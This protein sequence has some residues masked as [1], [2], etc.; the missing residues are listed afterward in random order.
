MPLDETSPQADDSYPQ[1]NGYPT[2][3][4]APL[5]QYKIKR[6]SIV[7]PDPFTLYFGFGGTWNWQRNMIDGI[8]KRAEHCR[9]L[10]Q[11]PPTQEEVDAFVTH[12][13]RSLYHG[14]IGAPVA[15]MAAVIRLY[16]QAK[17][18]DYYQM[19]VPG[20]AEGRIPSP[21]QLATGIRKFASLDPTAFRTTLA[22]TA[23]R[24]FFWT[25]TGA[26]VTSMYSV[27][28]DA[29]NT[30]SDPRLAEFVTAVRE[31]KPEEVR[32]RKLE[33]A[34][35][36]YHQTQARKQQQPQLDVMEPSEEGAFAEGQE[37]DQQQDGYSSLYTGTSPESPDKSSNLPDRNMGRLYGDPGS[38]SRIGGGKDSVSDF[39][40]DASPT[41]PE[42]QTS[43]RAPTNVFQ[44]GA[45]D[46]IRK[47]NVNSPREQQGYSRQQPENWNFQNNGGGGNSNYNSSDQ[48]RQ[49]EKEQA[50]V[51]FERMLDAERNMSS[52]GS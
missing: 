21:R 46:R 23:F 50:K 42:Y 5:Q 30:F 12:S 7:T 37:H 1:Q 26:T 2:N 40:D 3:Q 6:E 33:A 14:R 15:G 13:S 4:T 28:R 51:D 9:V 22:A 31:Q 32:K 47:Q 11:R 19:L 18:T 41:A 24:L 43:D 34:S 39:F 52:D 35:E 29:I 17:N 10:I 38:G 20:A 16:T 36:R 49:Q 48:E 25:I 27:Y 45:W 44:R 8:T